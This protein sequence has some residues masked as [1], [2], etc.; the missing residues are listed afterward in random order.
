MA[1]AVKYLLTIEGA[2]L[3]FMVSVIFRKGLGTIKGRRAT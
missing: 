1:H 3:P 2:F